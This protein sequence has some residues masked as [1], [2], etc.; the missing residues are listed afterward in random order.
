M[1]KPFCMSILPRA[2]VVTQLEHVRIILSQDGD[3][4]TLL[5]D[6]QPCLLLVRVAKVDPVKLKTA[7]IFR[8]SNE[9]V[10][11]GRY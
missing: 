11:A 4:V 10:S 6:D 1:I 3:R 2:R 8:H 9:S 7:T 5:A